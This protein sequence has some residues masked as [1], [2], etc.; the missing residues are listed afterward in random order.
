MIIYSTLKLGET[1]REVLKEGEV[2][3][4]DPSDAEVIL[5]WPTQVTQILDR[6]PKLKYIQTFS[7]GVD[8]LPF[9]KLPKGVR[10]FSNA[11]A[12]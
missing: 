1:A 6:A 4:D 12:Y 3:Y 5:A 11:G 9:D 7:A 2:S 8:G 10:V